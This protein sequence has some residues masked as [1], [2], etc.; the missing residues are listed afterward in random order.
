M[1]RPTTDSRKRRLAESCLSAALILSAFV[2]LA[3]WS[4]RKWPDIYVDFGNQLYIPWQLASGKVLYRD[5]M[6]LTGG[7]LSQ[8]IHALL[9]AFCGVSLT[10]LVIFNLCLLLLFVWMVYR[11]FVSISDR[12]TATS[13][14]LVT[15]SVFSFSQ[16]VGIANY[17]YVCPYSYEAF[18]GLVLS[19]AGIACLSY[20][21]QSQRLRWN[22]A[23]GVC[24]GAVFMTKPDL[25]LAL[26]ATVCTAVVVSQAASLRIRTAGK[27]IALLLVGHAFPI[28]LLVLYYGYTWTFRG[29]FTAAAGAWIPV[30]TTSLPQNAFYWLLLGLDHPWQHLL[31]TVEYFLGFCLTTALLA[32]WSRQ[33]LKPRILTTVPLSALLLVI[34]YLAAARFRWMACGR[35]L[36][37]FMLL[38]CG[39][40][41]WI[42]WRRQRHATP[43]LHLLFPL[44]WSVFALAL[45]AKMGLHT[46]IW[47]YGFYLA[48]PAAVFVVFSL[49]WTAP[50]S[51]RRFDVNPLAF[52]LLVTVFLLV[53]LFSLLRISNN[54]YQLKDFQIG[55]GGDYIVSYGPHLVSTGD[56]IQQAVD[57]LGANTSPNSTVATL[58]EGVMINYLARRVNPTPFP[59][60]P[61]PE[62]LAHGEAK[63]LKA[64]AQTSPD[65]IVLFH[66]DSSEFGAGNF[67]QES[68][69]GIDMMRW[70]RVNYHVV[71]QF[72][73]EPFQTKRF[74]IRILARKG[75]T[76]G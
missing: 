34:L 61:P 5:L 24:W 47:H 48:M 52:R 69:F 75:R 16:F 4:W 12:W 26:S 14:C 50:R 44:L 38:G 1:N 71:W 57:W 72:R 35:P 27:T 45:L 22:V 63:I 76:A 17:N 74:G 64:Y 42:W 60:L 13:V 40:T 41:A 62:F 23:A 68:G 25:Y 46:R 20:W 2:A 32:V 59:V 65:Y 73:D 21:L 37:L 9:F 11:L 19:V 67:G 3:T 36:L 30:L 49:M 54:Y 51:F 43:D 6:Y 53:G 56:G 15:L 31:L 33:F 39:F 10:V 18:H 70:I 28:A 29:G 66:R 7:P 55:R 8:H 58:L